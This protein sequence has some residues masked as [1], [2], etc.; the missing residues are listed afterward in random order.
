MWELCENYCDV[1][2]FGKL[3]FLR[4]MDSFFNIMLFGFLLLSNFWFRIFFI[5]VD[6]CLCVIWD[7]FRLLIFKFLYFSVKWYLIIL[8]I[9][10]K[11]L[12]FCCWI[13]WWF[14]FLW[15]VVW[16]IDCLCIFFFM[17]WC[18]VFV[19]FWLCYLLVGL[20]SFVVILN[21]FI[22]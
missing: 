6:F 11:N 21:G 3:F 8:Y 15:I 14:I 4:E 9:V 7:Y 1:S 20:I 13:I 18:K 19:W 16:F 5:Y 2:C 10:F 17:I 12:F 22:M